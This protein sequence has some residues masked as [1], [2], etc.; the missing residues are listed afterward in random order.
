M[1]L[2]QKKL[3]SLPQDQQSFLNDVDKFLLA[4]MPSRPSL[5]PEKHSDMSILGKRK[6]YDENGPD[7]K[8]DKFMCFSRRDKFKVRPQPVLTIDI[9]IL[10]VV[11]E[12]MED[13]INDSD[14]ST[15]K[16][17]IPLRQSMIENVAKLSKSLSGEFRYLPEDIK[18]RIGNMLL[19]LRERINAADK[20]MVLKKYKDMG[21]TEDEIP[22]P[23]GI[24][25]LTGIAFKFE[26]QGGEYSPYQGVNPTDFGSM[27][28]SLRKL[29]YSCKKFNPIRFAVLA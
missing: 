2:L 13:L 7:V 25:W 18:T 6:Y 24:S 10:A 3:C 28:R 4:P 19:V 9:K 12:N 11:I 23:T 29:C 20:A 27:M 15:L 1:L 21:V 26:M 16:D 5:F 17:N 22:S 14:W 8:H